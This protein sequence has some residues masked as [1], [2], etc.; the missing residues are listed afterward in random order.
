M[1]KNCC[2]KI[3]CSLSASRRIC[4]FLCIKDKESKMLLG[5]QKM[6]KYEP[7]PSS[8]QQ[9]PAGSSSSIPVVCFQPHVSKSAGNILHNGI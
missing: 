9:E 5:E 8:Y 7:I 2:P 1:L 3:I 6:N 4:Y